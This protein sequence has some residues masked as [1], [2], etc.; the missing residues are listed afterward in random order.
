MAWRAASRRRRR[1]S[2]R[3]RSRS[4]RARRL[5]AGR[6]SV[7]AVK[8]LLRLPGIEQLDPLRARLRRLPGIAEVDPFADDL[9]VAELHD[10][11]DHHRLVVVPD[12]VLVDPEVVAAG[13]AAELEV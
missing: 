2:R 4:R 1:R 11:D 9:P 8:H 12:R 6:S 10:A 13:D 3:T 5:E 7:E